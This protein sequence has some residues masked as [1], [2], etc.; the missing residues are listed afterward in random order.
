VPQL[1]LAGGLR[2]AIAAARAAGH[3]PVRRAGGRLEPG[4]DPVLP[5]PPGSSLG[6]GSDGAAGGDCGGRGGRPRALR[7]WHL[8]LTPPGPGVT[9]TAISL[10]R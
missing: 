7:R 5:R 3:R 8:A 9:M 4:R 6:A 10:G 1:D 2:E